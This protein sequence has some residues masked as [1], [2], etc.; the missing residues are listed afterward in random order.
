M[1]KTFT[2]LFIAI[3]F[4]GI[5]NIFP[6][7]LF[8]GN[9]L[10]LK[11][12]NGHLIISTSEKEL[13]DVASI[14]FNFTAPKSISVLSNNENAAKLKFVYPGVAEYQGSGEDLIDT[15]TIS[16]LENGLR[17]FCNSKW[18][19]N[20]TIQLNDLNEHY[21]GVL[22]PLYPN[23]EKSPDL[24][25]KVV[26]VDVLGDA[27]QYHENYASAWS[28]FYM[29]SGGY[30]S[31]FDSFAKGQY[32][33][34]ING[35]TELYHRTGKLDWYIIYGTSGDEI[36][37]SYYSII[38]NPKYIPIWACGPIIWRDEDKNG[39]KDVLDDAQKMA[40]MKIPLT[41]FMVDRPYS[42]GAH[43]WSK[44]DFNE[45]FSNPNEWI[46]ELNNKYNVQF[47]TWVGPLTLADKDFPGL[48]PNFKGYIDLSNP[49]AIKE[50]EKRL[51]ENL[52]SVNVRGHKMDRAD[53]EFPEYAMWYDK[54]PFAEHR[55]KYIYLYAKVIDQFLKEAYGKDEFNFARAAFHRTQ[56]YLSALWGGDS[57]S[58]W[59]GL[60][61]NMANAIRCGFMG[62]P[63]WGSDVG[64][65]LGGWISEDLYARWLQFGTWSGMFEI[66]LDHSGGKGKDRPPWK[67]SE[68]LQDIF[69]ETCVQRME[70]LP[71]IYSASN[72]SY[73]NG[74][75]MKPLAYEYF[76]DKNTYDIWDEYLFGNAFLVAPIY[77]STNSRSV[78]LPKG[79]WY[80]FN[81][82]LKIY[83]GGKSIDISVPMDKIPVFVKSNSIYVTGNIYQGSDKIWN[84]NVNEELSIHLF[85]GVSGE[86]TTYNYIDLNDS[87]KEKIISMTN[88]S[89][90]IFL[91]IDP[92][93]SNSR[94][95]IKLETEP[96]S[97]S[98]NG[99]QVK[100][101][102]NEDKGIVET[103]LKKE[104]QAI[105]EVLVK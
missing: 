59:D 37:K 83:A 38:G 55:N 87:D 89:G 29:S 88:E 65:Y 64:G 56:P 23:N 57:R 71:Y 105:I 36:L 11:L 28:A 34:A 90:K 22:E 20:I 3:I 99:S 49:D 75:M 33:F 72:T 54:T 92:L 14:N 93:K 100:Y 27:N 85:P 58:S 12:V 16:K 53:E 96:K 39:K 43:E 30:A 52:Y 35:T 78:Y 25:G 81:S 7:N 79:K 67:Y 102:W 1:K 45:K 2:L 47:L 94:L 10:Q 9:G 41:A 60:A 66:K 42:N 31:F 21:F 80:D 46:G 77:D 69:R 5:Q 68:K 95:N 17:F 51:K 44:M 84:D 61:G 6:Q 103:D 50:F 24:R 18:S 104:T 91:K 101:N 62:F 26:D 19:K 86:K 15:I 98:I 74:V 82:L 32:R 48:L 8:E 40:D 97:V 13:V 76:D 4:V 70:M 63:V 73:K